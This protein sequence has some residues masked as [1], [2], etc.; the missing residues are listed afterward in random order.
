MLVKK[1]RSTSF[2]THAVS[3]VYWWLQ[4]IIWSKT[5]AKHLC[6][7]IITLFVIFLV[8][9]LCITVHFLWWSCIYFSFCIIYIMYMQNIDL[10]LGWEMNSPI[11]SNIH[12][13]ISKFTGVFK[14]IFSW[15]HGYTLYTLSKQGMATYY[16]IWF[17]VSVKI[18]V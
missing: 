17:H 5:K 11:L 14:N 1:C 6:Q 18:I 9:T 16:N 7:S 8:E 10:F 4:N 3:I 15:F 2:R 13:E 12:G